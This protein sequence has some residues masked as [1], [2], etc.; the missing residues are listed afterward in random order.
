VRFLRDDTA[1]APE[2]AEADWLAAWPAWL[3]S[4]QVLAGERNPHRMAWREPCEQ[5]RRLAPTAGRQVR[6]F[7]LTRMDRYR[8]AAVEG[9]IDEDAAALLALNGVDQPRVDTPSDPIL[10]AVASAAAAHPELLPDR[11]EERER[12]TGLMTGYFEPRIDASAERRAPYLTP[13]Y[14]APDP[15]PIATRAQLLDSGALRGHELAW[16]RDPIEAFFLEVQGSGRLRL[17]DGSV[18]RVAYAGSNG[19]P[20]R[21]IGRWLLD[22]GELAP[23]RLSMQAIA[24][25]AHAHPW[26]VRELLNQNPRMVFFRALPVGDA[27]AGPVGSLGVALTPGVSVAVDPRYLPLGAPLLI[28]TVDPTGPAALVRVAV[29]QDTGGAIRGP[30]RIDWFWGEGPQAGA[31]AGHQRAMGTVRVLVPRGTDPRDLL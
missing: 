27:A 5:A 12:D 3:A 8:V 26:R 9:S 18:I 30:L 25:W 7:F 13:I 17:T 31:V 4:C 6:D 21:S 14:S 15:V 24:D 28:S 1:P 10:A 29:A 2:I 23:G 11:A 22:Q 19:Q 16:L 20:Y